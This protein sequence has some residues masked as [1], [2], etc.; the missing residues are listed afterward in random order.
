MSCSRVHD[1]R[2]RRA[3]RQGSGADIAI[4]ESDGGSRHTAD[5]DGRHGSSQMELTSSWTAPYVQASCFRG[6][7]ACHK[8]VHCLFFCYERYTVSMEDAIPCVNERHGQP[9]PRMKVQG[10]WIQSIGLILFCAG[11]HVAHDSSMTVEAASVRRST[12]ADMLKRLLFFEQSQSQCLEQV[13][14]RGL[15][16]CVEVCEA[17]GVQLPRELVVWVSRPVSFPS[18]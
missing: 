6:A 9:R 8:L 5:P 10:V 3:S 7:A 15:E 17:R 18:L 12:G 4:R 1:A 11:P 16:R 2:Q 14:C 13:I